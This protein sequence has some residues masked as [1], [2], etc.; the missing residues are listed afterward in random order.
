ML[1]ERSGAEREWSGAEWCGVVRLVRLPAFEAERC[2]AVRSG[3][4]RCRA[5]RSG[6][7]WSG[8]EERSGAETSGLER[9]RVVERGISQVT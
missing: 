3:A 4:E 9:R 6:A 1:V 5:V 8:E 7:E 2:G